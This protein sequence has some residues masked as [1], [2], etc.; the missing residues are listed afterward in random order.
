MKDN[1]NIIDLFPTPL[2]ITSIS[3]N[4]DLDINDFDFK[5]YTDR[6]T[7]TYVLKL[8]KYY[9]LK[10]EILTHINKFSYELGY[11]HKSYRITQSWVNIKPIS[12]S[13]H[14]HNHANSLISGVFYP[15]NNPDHIPAINFHKPEENFL[16]PRYLPVEESPNPQYSD[17]VKIKVSRNILILFPSYLAHSVDPNPNPQFRYSL[18]FNSIP[19]DSL[20]DENDLTE[21]KF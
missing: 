16:L 14:R 19:L 10:Q 9:N 3:E 7:N 13:H 17:T 1:F 21:L 6:S 4:N 18:A 8:Q 12:N 5:D 20:G 15:K 2:Y 11:A